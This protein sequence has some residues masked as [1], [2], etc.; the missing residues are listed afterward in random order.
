MKF[1][2]SFGCFVFN[3]LCH[4]KRSRESS[5]W[6]SREIDGKAEGCVIGNERIKSLNSM[7]DEQRTLEEHAQMTDLERLRHSASH[8][9]VKAI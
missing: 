5:G 6:G 7:S 3:S 8:V 2:V 9:L 1:F 4:S